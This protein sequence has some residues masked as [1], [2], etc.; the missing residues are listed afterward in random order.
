[1][2]LILRR[3]GPAA[4]VSLGGAGLCRVGFCEVVG[5]F[6][7]RGGLRVVFLEGRVAA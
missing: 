7:S 2:T 3:A 4:W 6:P 5:C 1:M